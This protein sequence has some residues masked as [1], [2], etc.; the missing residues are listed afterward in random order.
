V[1]VI[2]IPDVPEILD[3]PWAL[4]LRS[5]GTG[6]W[7]LRGLATEHEQVDTRIVYGPACVTRRDAREEWSRA[8]ECEEQSLY[9]CLR[10]DGPRL[11]LVSDAERLLDDEPERLPDFLDALRRAAS[12][13]QLHVVFQSRFEHADDRLAVFQEFGVVQAA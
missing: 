5:G 4:L 11:V 7:L 8:L 3:G 12:D 6:L 2:R 13:T 10:A 9:D 1:T